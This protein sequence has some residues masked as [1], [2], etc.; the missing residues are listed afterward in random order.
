MHDHT[1]LEGYMI[2]VLKNI[3]QSGI[4]KYCHSY[5]SECRKQNPII[6]TVTIYTSCNFINVDAL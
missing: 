6:S 5:I 4:I 2:Y 1:D 3:R